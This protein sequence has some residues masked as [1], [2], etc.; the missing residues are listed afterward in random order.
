MS[1][2][3]KCPKCGSQNILFL[4]VEIWERTPVYKYDKEKNK[5]VE[6]YSYKQPIFVEEV[7][8]SREVQCEDCGWKAGHTYA[9][10]IPIEMHD[11]FDR[12]KNIINKNNSDKELKYKIYQRIVAKHYK[13]SDIINYNNEI[14][15]KTYEGNIKASNDL[16]VLEKLYVKFNLD[17]RPTGKYAT[18]LSIGDIIKLEDKYYICEV[19]GFKD[20]TDKI[21]KK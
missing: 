1:I 16:S 13:T 11:V 8:D 4:P 14:L 9:E 21:D 17:D 15:Y 2:K 10:S 12:S 5:F 20:I 6:K 7:Y 19:I 3:I 18:S